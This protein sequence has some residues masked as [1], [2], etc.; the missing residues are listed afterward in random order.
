MELNYN[1]KNVKNDNDINNIIKEFRRL[2]IFPYKSNYI[3]KSIE[4]LFENLKNYNVP[5]NKVNKYSINNID[6]FKSHLVDSTFKKEYFQFTND[7]LNNYENINIL[8]DYF[9]EKCRM[10]CKKYNKI[11]PFY[12][13]SNNDNLKKI[14]KELIKTKQDINYVNIRE[15]IYKKGECENFKLTLAISIYKYFNAT[16]ILDF[17]AG[18]GDR[19]ISAIAYEENLNYY[20]GYDPSEC[21]NKYY[22]SIIS[23]LAKNKLKFKVTKLPF[24]KAKLNYSY[25]LIFTSPP[26]FSLE[27]YNN[28]ESQSINQYNKLS[29]WFCNM[30]IKW[31]LLSWSHLDINGYMV[32]NI[33]DIVKHDRQHLYTEATVLFVSGFFKR[34]KYLGVI[35]YANDNKPNLVRPFWV[36]RKEDNIDDQLYKKK[37]RDEFKKYYPDE[38]NIIKKN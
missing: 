8:S 12:H 10:L 28:E 20:H 36:W 33:E 18:W 7:N 3:K 30:L 6:K 27:I 13:F 11:A 35:G 31:L 25:D 9:S 34:A 16:R 29:E 5:V 15:L 22:N 38:Y 2:I 17:C 1:Y 26:Y 32:I 14:I 4:D 37:Y 24:E 21:M 23:L 19:L